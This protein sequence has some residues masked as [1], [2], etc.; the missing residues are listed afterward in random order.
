MDHSSRSPVQSQFQHVSTILKRLLD[1]LTCAI[2]IASFYGIL[3]LVSIVIRFGSSVH[4]STMY[5]QFPYN[6]FCLFPVSPSKQ[7]WQYGCPSLII[8]FLGPAIATILGCSAAVLFIDS[9]PAAARVA[10]V[11]RVA[12]RTVPSIIGAARCAAAQPLEGGV[13]FR[14]T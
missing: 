10:R 12:F 7:I 14:I 9:T 3:R 13:G 1:D 11:G 8:T 4:T 2:H 5:H 6:H